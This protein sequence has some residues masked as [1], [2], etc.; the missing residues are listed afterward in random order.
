M[1]NIF[2]SNIDLSSIAGSLTPAVAGGLTTF[3]LLGK[4]LQASLNNYAAPAS[5]LLM[6]SSGFA[7]PVITNGVSGAT[8]NNFGELFLPDTPNAGSETIFIVASINPSSW[9]TFNASPFGTWNGTGGG[10]AQSCYMNASNGL[11]GVQF[12]VGY[13]NGSGTPVTATAT[14]RVN[15]G[16]LGTTPAEQAIVSVPQLYM[17]KFDIPDLI[18][19]FR[20]ITQAALIGAPATTT[21][22]VALTAGSTR[23]IITPTYQMMG[24]VQSPTN[25]AV[26]LHAIARYNRATLVSED[27]LITAQLQKI[28]AVRSV[29]V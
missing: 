3:A 26:T 24:N 6:S 16:S 29:T 8:V 18:M 23:P 7:F 17:M 14:T 22:T 10:L 19:T 27:T 20:N 28:M 25:S 21:G 2:D 5:P 12:T 4:S 13:I 9:T 15:T 11:S 1:P